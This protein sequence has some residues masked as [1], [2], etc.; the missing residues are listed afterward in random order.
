MAIL[1]LQKNIVHNFTISG[2]VGTYLRIASFR[3]LA[4]FMPYRFH[5]GIIQ[6]TES[7]ALIL[8]AEFIARFQL[9][10]A[11]SIEICKFN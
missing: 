11:N 9:K 7:K 3:A 4:S 5:K 8:C 6:N 1:L 10:S 2:G